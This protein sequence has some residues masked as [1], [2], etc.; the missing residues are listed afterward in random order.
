[1][2]W[3]VTDQLT[4]TAGLRY[5]KEKKHATGVFNIDDP[6]AALNFEDMFVAVAVAQAAAAAAG[7]GIPP[8]VIATVVIPQAT[9]GARAV[10]DNPA[11]NP[12]LGFGALQF[13]PPRDDF[14]RRR[15]EDKLTGNIILAYDWNDDLNTYASFSRGYKAGGFDT[16]RAATSNDPNDASTYE[17]EPETVDAFEIGA[18]I[19]FWDRRA[20]VNIAAYT[21][22]VDD[23]QSNIFTGLGFELRNAG[24][25]RIKGI[26]LDSQ[27][28]LSEN[29]N[30][31]FA[32]AYSDAEYTS[33]TGA[34]C[35]VTNPQPSCDPTSP[36]Y[37]GS[38]DLTGTRLADAP[39]FTFTSTASYVRPL[40]DDMNGF[41]QGEIY[42]RGPRNVAGD[43]DPH[44]D[45]PSTLILN[46]SVGIEGGEDSRWRVSA[47]VKNLTN[48]NYLQL[49][50]DSV[51]Q[52][53]SFNGYPNDPRTYGVTLSLD[54]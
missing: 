28:A 1:V 23:F 39:K 16:S 24:S 26:E 44:G 7:Q 27:F 48:E 8:E 41:M 3:H 25:M 52:S 32:A 29:L 15:S 37:T 17:F 19:R 35:R 4:L 50:F 5:T 47:W 13:F 34:P 12:L 46:A 54:F 20:Q 10:A 11:V 14:D 53:G 40:S 21:Q 31:T 43:L 42:Y 49:I 45:M 30:W 38:A 51:A 33:Y 18:K 2:D 6:F 9:A 22:K 36:S